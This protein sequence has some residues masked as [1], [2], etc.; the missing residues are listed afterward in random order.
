[1]GPT[2]AVLGLHDLTF[3]ALVGALFV[4]VFL[5]AQGTYWLGRAVTASARRLRSRSSSLDLS[6]ARWG[7]R[8]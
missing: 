7:S 2:P 1:M 4:V 3:P 5:R 6:G 8:W